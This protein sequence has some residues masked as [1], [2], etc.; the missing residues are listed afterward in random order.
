MENI[1]YFLSAIDS[2]QMCNG[3]FENLLV[4]FKIQ[5]ENIISPLPTQGKIYHIPWPSRI[6][7][8]CERLC[9]IILWLCIRFSREVL[10]VSLR[11]LG[12]VKAGLNGGL[13][14]KSGN[15]I[16]DILGNR[17]DLVCERM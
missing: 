17:C 16:K 5:I 3:V 4:V 8:P 2:F 9:Y 15:R 11:Y 7:F 10:I 1:P 6:V 13:M 14:N 12:L